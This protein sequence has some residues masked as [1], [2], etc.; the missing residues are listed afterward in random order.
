VVAPPEEILDPELVICDPHHHLW[1]Q[2]ELWGQMQPAYLLTDLQAD[3]QAGHHV[4]SSVY[5]EARSQYRS[6]GPEQ[7]RP[8]GETE[9]V[10]GMHSDFLLDGIVGFADL[11]LGDAVE[12]VLVAHQEAGAG[13]FRGIRHSSAWDPSPDIRNAASNP[14]GDMMER[15][16]FRRGVATLGRL[17]LTYDAWLFHPQIPQ[18]YELAR[19]QPDVTMIL[20]HLGGPLGIGPYQGRRDEVLGDV[21]RSLD[22]L[23]ECPN[24]VIKL[25]GVGMTIFG[26]GW[27]KREERVSSEEVAEAYG[28]I[29]RWAIERFGVDRCMFESNF[30]VDRHSADYVVLWNAFKR[31]TAD[32][33]APERAALFHDTATRVYRLGGTA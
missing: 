5:I 19:S 22:Q 17:G 28:P 24:V 14:P 25:G 31:I 26:L 1:E 10:A 3:A 7:L 12:E 32:L 23:A 18:L 8:V 30:P 21:R 11:M 13:R 2:F 4:V 20:D 6:D 16:D 15:D 29:I 27:H 9:W 33:S